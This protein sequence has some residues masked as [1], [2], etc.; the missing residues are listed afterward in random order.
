MTGP[1]SPPANTSMFSSAFI[2]SNTVA[3]RRETVSGSAWSPRSLI[4]MARE[5]KCLI[6]RQGSSSNFGFQHQPV[7][8]E[9]KCRIGII[10]ICE[11]TPRRLLPVRDRPAVALLFFDQRA[12]A[13]AERPRDFLRRDRRGQFV[14]IPWVFR[15]LGLLDLEQIG[16][17]HLAAVGADGAL[18]EQDVV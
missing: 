9:Q 10:Q 7:S 12:L 16:R 13:F 8:R 2:A 17:K 3:T 18:A 1:E 5:S 11:S 4:F 15:F 14:V 6:T